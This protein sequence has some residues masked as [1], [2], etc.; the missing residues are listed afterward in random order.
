MEHHTKKNSGGLMGVVAVLFGLAFIILPLMFSEAVTGTAQVILTSFGVLLLLTGGIVVT[1]TKLY[2]KTSANE[3]FVRTGMGGEKTIISGGAL[4]LPVVHNIIWVSLETMKLV[5]KRTGATALICGDKLRADVVSEFYIKIERDA[6]SVQSAA[7]SLGGRSV[8]GDSIK[9]LVEEKFVSALRTVSSTMELMDLHQNRAKF[10]GDVQAIVS[11][12]L[13]PNG[14]TLETVTISTLDQTPV[15]S[16]QSGENIFDAQGAR[17]V[18]EIVESQRVATTKIKT[19]ADQDVK[20]EEVTRDKFIFAQEYEAAKAEA[21]RDALIKKVQAEQEQE[22]ATVTA[23]QEEKT[24]IAQVKKEENIALAGVTKEK[25]LEVANKQRE[26][27]AETA[28]IEKQK[29]VEL[30]AQDK[31][32][33]VAGKE[34]EKAEAQKLKFDAEALEEESRQSV[35]TV[36]EV[37]TADRAKKTAIIAEEAEAAKSKVK[38]NTKADVDAYTVTKKASADMEAAENKAQAI[39]T[40]AQADRDAKVAEAEGKKALEMI[41]VEVEGARVEVRQK[42]VEVTGT[43]LKYKAEHQEISKELEIALA[44]IA[45]DKEIGVAKAQA[46]GQ[47]LSSA[48]MQI[49]GDSNMMSTITKL[50][51]NG[52]A[53]AAAVNGFMSQLDEEGENVLV[54]LKTL[55]EKFGHKLGD[56]AKAK[57]TD[58]I[59]ETVKK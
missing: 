46:L 12:D 55:V 13:A 2:V 35:R 28:D 7:T 34:K 56:K 24:G 5:V 14:L 23:Q 21:E 36:T 33:A 40:Q 16:M 4:V 6:Q 15:N 19:K 9:E 47:A 54:I 20:S 43:E 1:I 51:T 8:N 17:K 32:I 39:R 59:S 41:P 11:K 58:V 45:K 42:D 22:A 30:A 3:A 53:G 18:A 44:N 25:N 31:E 38:E 50:F 37:E 49:W 29:A 27:A 52:Q 48:N 57:I 10:A 26:Q